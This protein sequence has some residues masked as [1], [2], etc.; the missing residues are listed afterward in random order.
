MLKIDSVCKL[1][2]TIKA[3]SK[4]DAKGVPTTIASIKFSELKI[5][6]IEGVDELLGEKS[7]WARGALYDDQA[8]QAQS[9]SC[10]LAG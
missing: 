6:G 3:T 10:S 5:D 7:G 1:G 8:P 4:K 2:K 9:G